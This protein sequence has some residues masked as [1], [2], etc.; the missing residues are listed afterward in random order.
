MPA[1]AVRYAD[2]PQLWDRIPDLFA[3]VWPEYNLHGGVM[4]RYWTRL[5]EE[6]GEFQLALYDSDEDDIL[7]TGRTIPLHWDGTVSGLGTGLDA[8]IVAGFAAHGPE[9]S[10]NALC[11][12]GV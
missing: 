1:T 11:A 3:G 5:F 12:L 2:R 6:F 7:A 4:A 10:P 9:R 8:A